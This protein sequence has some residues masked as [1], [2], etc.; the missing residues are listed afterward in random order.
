MAIFEEATNTFGSVQVLIVNHGYWPP[1]DVP[2][3]RM[4]LD[5]WNS[6]ISTD[7][8]STFLVIREFLR[9]LEKAT[10]AQ[11]EKAAIVM[12]GSTAGKFGEAGHSDYA[13]CKSGAFGRTGA[14]YIRMIADKIPDRC[15][16]R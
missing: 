16:K 4:T 6:T 2:L 1:E 12:I 7:L 15:R 9:N 13:A 14:V 3:M 5:Q 11:K 10:P 8:T